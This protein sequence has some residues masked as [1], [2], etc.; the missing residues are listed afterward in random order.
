MTEILFHLCM[1]CIALDLLVYVKT[2]QS[3]WLEILYA[4]QIDKS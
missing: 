1:H 3:K 4:I 2:V